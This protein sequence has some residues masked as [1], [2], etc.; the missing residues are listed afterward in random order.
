M[1]T[2]GKAATLIFLTLSYPILG[3]AQNGKQ[4]RIAEL[5]YNAEMA[6]QVGECG[7]GIT[8]VD[9]DIL[10]LNDMT[11]RDLWELHPV[12]R[13]AAGGTDS[14]F[15]ERCQCPGTRRDRSGVGEI[16]RDCMRRDGEGVRPGHD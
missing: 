6:H 13:R 4:Q 10:F 2:R 7:S 12:L 14:K 5:A 1:K 8:L 9:R 3:V 11:G 16:S 15:A